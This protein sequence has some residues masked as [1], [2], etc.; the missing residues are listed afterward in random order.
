MEGGLGMGGGG[1]GGGRGRSERET[2]DPVMEPGVLFLVN[3]HGEREGER[4]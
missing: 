2:P 3:L 4:D 1:G